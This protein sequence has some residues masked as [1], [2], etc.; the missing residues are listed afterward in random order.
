MKIASLS[1]LAALSLC[2]PVFGQAPIGPASIKL[3]KISPA[4]VKTPEYNITGGQTKRYKLG[5]WLEVE[6]EYETKPEIIDE[7]TFKFVIMVEGKLLDGE[8]TYAD[9]A[10]GNEHYAVMY[11]SPKAIN[12]LT[13]GKAL[14]GASIGNVWVE[15]LRSGQKLA[16]SS[17]KK[18]A[19]PNIQHTAGL[20]LSK[21]QTPFE[22][23]Y[24][25]RYEA[26]KKATR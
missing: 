18:D 21:D 11:V 6:V 16:Q 2:V 20:V 24:Y 3:K 15:I 13:K 10:E 22:P 5:D 14:T 25:D 1:L 9:I 12:A 23:L 4:V 26:I 17:Y 7:L 19:M 8:V